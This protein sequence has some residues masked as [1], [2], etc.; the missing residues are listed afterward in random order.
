[1][2]VEPPQPLC[3]KASLV[4]VDNHFDICLYLVYKYFIEGFKIYV[5]LGYCPIIF[6]MFV[7]LSNFG[8][9]VILLS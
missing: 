1:M 7:F 2:Y 9:G 8:I 4:M 6:F 3:D 5:H